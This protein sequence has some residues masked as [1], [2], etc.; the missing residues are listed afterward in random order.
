M[1]QYFH[2]QRLATISLKV[3]TWHT[4]VIVVNREN[5]SFSFLL[6]TGMRSDLCLNATIEDDFPIQKT[7]TQGFITNILGNAHQKHF[8][9]LPQLQLETLVIKN[10]QGFSEGAEAEEA[11]LPMKF[12]CQKEH[13]HVEPQATIGMG[14]LSRYNFFL[15]LH[16]G[17]ISFFHKGVVPKDI[18]KRRY[19]KIPL[20][21]EGKIP[22]VELDTNFGKKK[23]IIDTGTTVC[24]IPKKMQPAYLNE[25]SEDVEMFDM[26]LRSGNFHLGKHRFFLFDADFSKVNA[27]GLIGMDF[28]CKYDLFFDNIKHYLY[29]TI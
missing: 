20:I 17:E 22:I 23:F 28:L 6:D 27:D 24:I 14:I 8:F 3:S 16:L 19:L 5:K 25:S 2:N 12:I 26:N 18:L 21:F 29:L 1:H 10:I 15:D 9:Y 7:D 13:D 4:P 11:N